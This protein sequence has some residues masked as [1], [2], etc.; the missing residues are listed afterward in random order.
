M[1]RKRIKPINR[2]RTSGIAKVC[3]VCGVAYFAPSWKPKS[4]YCSATCRQKGNR[5]APARTHYDDSV[6]GTGSRGY[7]KWHGRH[8]HHR[9]VAE[10]MIGR[11]LHPG[12]IVHHKN[13]D[14]HDNRPE[15]LEVNTQSNHCRGHATKNRRCTVP[16]CNRKHYGHGLCSMHHQRK[17]K[18]G[19]AE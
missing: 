17:A 7:V 10:Q 9:V 11:L 12:E 1:S 8:Q 13:G 14:K 6:R 5:H 4:K 2:A 19:D 18:G 15:N 3:R 16:G